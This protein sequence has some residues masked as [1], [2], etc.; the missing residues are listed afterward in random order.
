MG[1]YQSDQHAPPPSICS[2]R[3]RNVEYVLIPLLPF[4]FPDVEFPAFRALFRAR[5][6]SKT[7]F[8]YSRSEDDCCSTQG[9]HVSPDKLYDAFVSRQSAQLTSLRPSRSCPIACA[10][11]LVVTDSSSKYDAVFSGHRIRIC[12]RIACRNACDEA[13]PWSAGIYLSHHFPDGMFKFVAVAACAMYV[14]QTGGAILEHFRDVEFTTLHQNGS[15]LRAIYTLRELVNTPLKH[16]SAGADASDAGSPSTVSISFQTQGNRYLMGVRQVHVLIIARRL[17]ALACMLPCGNGSGSPW[18]TFELR[19]RLPVNE[20][21]VVPSALTSHIAAI[22]QGLV[23]KLH[24]TEHELDSTQGVSGGHIFCV[25]SH[26]PLVASSLEEAVCVLSHINRLCDECVAASAHS[27][28][29]SSADR[30]VNKHQF[31][32]YL[33]RRSKKLP[34]GQA[35][36]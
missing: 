24:S 21:I 5:E 27:S 12:G 13:L 16:M 2:L 22:L 34:S 3:T 8:Y 33:H 28:A 7:R 30:E 36:V 23:V 4:Y 10:V 20:T 11:G 26:A 15:M 1:A 19:C 25:Q 6:D 31:M 14:H 9:E 17:A 32:L 35:E 29:S 18:V